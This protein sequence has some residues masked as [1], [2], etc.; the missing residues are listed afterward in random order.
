[1]GKVDTKE[2]DLTTHQGRA[3]AWAAWFDLTP[4]PLRFDPEEPEALLMT[5][6][7]AA[8]ARG[9]CI[10]FTWFFEGDPQAMAKE[11]RKARMDE[12]EVIRVHRSLD[13]D[14][15]RLFRAVLLSIVEGE[16]AAED[17][18]VAYKDALAN[19]RAKKAAAA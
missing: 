8:W 1:M 9:A 10:D 5:D 17:V 15:Q 3:T 14:E 19:L 11:W 2:H 6:E 4:P 12:R 7:L 13:E 16:I 18:V